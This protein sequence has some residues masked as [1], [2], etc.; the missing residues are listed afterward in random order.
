MSN[1]TTFSTV[2]HSY[3]AARLVLIVLVLGLLAWWLLG[4]PDSPTRVLGCVWDRASADATA[5][6]AP[7][8]APRP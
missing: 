7:E 3:R 6:T 4:D 1:R 2:E 8:C 5:T